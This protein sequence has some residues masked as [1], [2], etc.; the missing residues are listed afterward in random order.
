MV[1]Q[2]ITFTQMQDEIFAF[3]LCL[4]M[5]GHLKFMYEAQNWT[6]SNWTMQGQTKAYITNCRQKTTTNSN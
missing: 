3:D 6:V 5:R 1:I 2:T 4:N